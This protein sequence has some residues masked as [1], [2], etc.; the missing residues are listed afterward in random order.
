M[1]FFCVDLF[2]RV[3]M[4]SSTI[5]LSVTIHDLPKQDHYVL[6]YEFTNANVSIYVY[7]V[8]QSVDH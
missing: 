3:V 6:P 8:I 4:N 2:L 5:F 7:F 1:P